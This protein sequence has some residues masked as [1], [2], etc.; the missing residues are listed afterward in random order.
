L[1]TFISF[2]VDSHTRL[3]PSTISRIFGKKEREI[4]NQIDWD[5]SL[6]L[7]D[8]ENKLIGEKSFVFFNN[9]TYMDDVIVIH[10]SID[11]NIH[12]EFDEEVMIDFTRIPDNVSQILFFLSNHQ[13]FSFDIPKI[14]V[15]VKNS[16]CHSEYSNHLSI[17]NENVGNAL[18]LF[19]FS[20]KSQSTSWEIE[21]LNLPISD[22]NGMSFILNKYFG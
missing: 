21:V 3:Y 18:E 16:P 6:L 8:D 2:N 4:A 22:A 12:S 5:I 19:K 15:F 17:S 13:T 11:N 20:R 9:P 1:K 14:E 10:S 7:L